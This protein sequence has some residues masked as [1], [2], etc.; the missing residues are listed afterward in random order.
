V[1]DD[2][3]GPAATYAIALGLEEFLDLEEL[4]DELH[5]PVYRG[6]VKYVTVHPV[7]R[8]AP[9]NLAVRAEHPSADVDIVGYGSTW[10]AAARDCLRQVR[11]SARADRA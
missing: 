11:A 3:A 8:P 1:A 7:A 4:L 10:L 2:A 5:D 9:D 6:V